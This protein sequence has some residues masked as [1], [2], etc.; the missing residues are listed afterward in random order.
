MSLDE[1][2][3]LAQFHADVEVGQVVFRAELVNQSE[4]FQYRFYNYR[5]TFYADKL[6]KAGWY[7]GGSTVRTG[8]VLPGKSHV[9]ELE[10]GVKIDDVSRYE[11]I[12]SPSWE[13]VE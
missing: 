11:L 12:I 10:T 2:S 9:I 7:G 1:Y 8:F 13:D 5:V 6:E 3:A 4:A